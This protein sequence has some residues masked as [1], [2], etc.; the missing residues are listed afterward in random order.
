[1]ISNGKGALPSTL[2][3]RVAH[4]M[5]LIQMAV[6][7]TIPVFAALMARGIGG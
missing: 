7:A 2:E 1:L 6:F 3:V 5:I 4:R